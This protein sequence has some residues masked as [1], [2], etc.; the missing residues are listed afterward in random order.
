MDNLE[1]SEIIVQDGQGN[2]QLVQ[3]VA[4]QEGTMIWD[5]GIKTALCIVQTANGKQ[6]A[7]KTFNLGSSSGGITEDNIIIKSDTIPTAAASNR[8]HIYIYTGETNANFTH[9]YIYENQVDTVIPVLVFVKVKPV[10]ILLTSS[11]FKK[12]Q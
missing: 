2:N 10:V 1:T 8:G 3:A 7:L 12:T 9:G 4:N 6:L 5:E 11:S